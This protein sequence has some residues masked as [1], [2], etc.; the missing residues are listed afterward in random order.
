MNTSAYARDPKPFF[1]RD[2][3]NAVIDRLAS[4]STL[5]LYVGAGAT[6]DQGGYTWSE[7]IE[8]MAS[9]MG[10]NKIRMSETDVLVLGK[11]LP[12]LE[13]ATAIYSK[14][15]DQR[16]FRGAEEPKKALD[17]CLARCLYP[18]PRWDQ[19]ELVRAVASVA[20]IRAICG[21]KTRIVTTNYDVLLEDELQLRIETFDAKRDA[22]GVAGSRPKL[23]VWTLD[24][25]AT[26]SNGRDG[27]TIDFIYLHGRIP[28]SQKEPAR[29]TVA[30]TELDYAELRSASSK[31]LRKLFR[32]SAVLVIGAS[33]TDPPLLSALQE[34]QKPEAD[35]GRGCRAALLPIPAIQ[36]RASRQINDAETRSLRDH[37]VGRMK[38]MNVTLL[39]PD[40]FSSVAQFCD[41]LDCAIY[42]NAQASGAGKNAGPPR[43]WQR[44]SNWWEQWYP[45]RFKNPS[46]MRTFDR[47][48]RAFLAEL[49][50]DIVIDQKREE[51]FKIDIWAI[52]DPKCEQRCLKRWASTSW[53]RSKWD[54]KDIEYLENNA[55]QAEISRCSSYPCV[56]ALIAGRPQLQRFDLSEMEKPENSPRASRWPTVLSVPILV[57]AEHTQT[58]VGVVTLSS[59]EVDSCLDD[60]DAAFLDDLVWRI[61]SLSRFG[62]ALE[63]LKATALNARAPKY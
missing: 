51:K 40:F 50:A 34:T 63:P 17:T 7:L 44:Y 23:K 49:T 60:R 56:A 24:Q 16:S 6:I 45:T 13:A 38:S 57:S 55:R 3:P 15:H 42:R 19:G 43:Y 31:L 32:S 33:L 22:Y 53:P 37:Q 27:R 1:T 18:P 61:R 5:T 9:D 52:W 48:L 21:Q 36:A 62:F 26:S 46:F 30:F 20:M 12:S 35:V 54:Q 58:A 10:R 59:R 14:F 2:E 28:S 41:E 29:G 25:G 11:L 47:Y 4:A 8:Q 39:V